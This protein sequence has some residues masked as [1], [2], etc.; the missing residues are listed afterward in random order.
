MPDILLELT[1]AAT[2]ETV[3]QAITDRQGVTSWWA[4]KQLSNRRSDRRQNS[5]SE[6]VSPSSPSR[7]PDLLI[8][9]AASLSGREQPRLEQ[10]DLMQR[11]E[12]VAALQRQI[13]TGQVMENYVFQQGA[14]DLHAKARRRKSEGLGW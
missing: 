4:L 1:I 9:T 13:P 12:R 14:R 8:G 3:Y 2:P 5:G 7:S 6:A 10:I 11:T